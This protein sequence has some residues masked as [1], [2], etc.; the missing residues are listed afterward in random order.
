MKLAVL[1]STAALISATFVAGT[2]QAAEPG[3]PLDEAA[4]KAAW[5]MASPDGKTISKDQ[6]VDYVI[7]Y[8]MVDSDADAAISEDEFKKG[9]AGG[10]IKYGD[11]ATVK[12][13][14]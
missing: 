7:N 2:A 8:S 5:T 9:C 13:M 3:K 1:A 4:C 14:D 10:W 6:A 11:E 12:D